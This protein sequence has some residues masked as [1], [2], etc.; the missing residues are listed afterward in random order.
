MQFDVEIQDQ[1]LLDWF[2]RFTCNDGRLISRVPV[3]KFIE[4]QIHNERSIFIE[5]YKLSDGFLLWNE[6]E[7]MSVDA[8]TPDEAQQIIEEMQDTWNDLAT[9]LNFCNK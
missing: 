3:G 2:N 6:W 7:F 9:A 5:V 1:T 8:K 4:E